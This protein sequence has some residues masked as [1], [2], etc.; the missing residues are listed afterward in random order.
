MAVKRYNGSSWDV[1]AGLGAQGPV[2]TSSSI[3]TWVKTASGG[4]TS[5]SGNDDSN[6]SLS[7][8]VGQELVFINGAL[9]KRGAD[10]TATTGTSITG[11][12]ALAAGDVVTVWTVNAFSVTNAI[13]SGLVTTTGDI[14]YAS[15][16]NTPARLGIGSTDQVLKVSG[17][18]PAWGAPA[19]SMT[20]ITSGTIPSGGLTLSS[21]SQSYTDLVFEVYGVTWSTS[22]Y[23]GIY[24]NNSASAA[25]N[26]FTIWGGGDTSTATA[27]SGTYIRFITNAW[28]TNANNSLIVKISDYTNTSMYKPYQ[29]WGY[30]DNGTTEYAMNGGG[31]LK[32]NNAIDRIDCV[33]APGGAN[34]TAGSYKLWGIK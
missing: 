20:L 14:I 13:S 27:A 19:G 8:A 31:G 23:Y 26:S 22:S 11:L 7:Y 9:Q 6:Q 2:G 5:L 24:F 18:I 3:A 17:G 1:V 12:N 28:S 15:A 10:Y 29:F 32:T 4:E 21:I 25:R 16:A 34:F 33:N 30:M